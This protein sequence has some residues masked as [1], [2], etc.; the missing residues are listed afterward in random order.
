MKPES[1]SKDTILQISRRLVAE[2]GLTA[3]NMRTLSEECG[4]AL[5]TLYH[6]YTNKDE[7]LLAVIESIWKDIFY[8][9]ALSDAPGFIG[10]VADFFER[11]KKGTADYPGFLFAHSAVIADTQKKQARNTMK[12]IF[13]HMKCCLL[14]FLQADPNVRQSS[15]SCTF[16]QEDFIEFVFD[17]LL[18]LLAKGEKN[19]ETLTEIIQRII[20]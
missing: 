14:A 5:G 7:L 15:F 16:S 10:Y 18:L 12:D 19:C 4:I 9:D 11:A 8:D 13:E 1:T 2:N 20:Y 17:H 6:Y 3:L